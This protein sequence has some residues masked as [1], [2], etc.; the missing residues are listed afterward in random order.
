MVN[1]QDAPSGDGASG[2]GTGSA[3]APARPP[4]FGS[5]DPSPAPDS[6]A[7]GPGATSS[8]GTPGATAPT[9]AGP[10]AVE[11]GGGSSG[12]QLGGG[13]EPGTSTGP[14][15]QAP[16]YTVPGFYGLP[17]TT[18]TGGT[19]RLARPRFRYSAG[20]SIGYDD[21]VFQT[22][23]KVTRQPDQL[24]LIDP[25]TPDILTFVPVTT[26]TYEQAFA[27]PIIYFRPVTTTRL[28]QVIIPGRDPVFETVR[29]PDPPERIG[30]FVSRATLQADMQ[31][32]TRR[33]LFTADL[34]TRLDHYWSRPKPSDKD[35]YSGTLALAYLYRITPRLQFS[36]ATNIAYITQPD[37]TRI[38]T[39]DRLGLGDLVNGLAR[40]NLSYRITPRLS[41]TLSISENA[42]YF[43]EAGREA[44]NSYETT[45]GTEVRYLWKPR[46]TLLA[47]LR[48]SQVTFPEF[49]LRDSS[50]NTVLLGGEVTL[51]SRLTAS[52]RFGAS[53]RT[54]DASDEVSTS[55]SVEAT[56][57][58]RLGATS[59]IQWNSRY[60][61]E[62]PPDQSSEVIAF[63]TSL[64]Y[65]K[66]F[67]PRL[68]ARASFFTV[69]RTTTNPIVNFDQTDITIEASLGLQYRVTRQVT[70]NG[71]YSFTQADTDEE[72][73][74]YVRN[75]LFFGVEYDF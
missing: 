56:L 73:T 75:R 48:H 45:F 21:N 44:N 49:T 69:Y 55:P 9:T 58:Y 60:G 8:F 4:V 5:P 64:T 30:S 1:A 42:V 46:Y 57:N 3:P 39:P 61:F 24:I 22:P 59:L 70:L 50:T 34:S 32:F 66:S 71:D 65:T 14:F 68:N 19:G 43:T 6:P 31:S 51:T 63:R 28:Q 40:M 33:S 10:G 36:L 54:F 23:S 29:A 37:L 15:E 38:N 52:I 67:T 18:Y 11:P 35:D 17:A 72:F 53:F 74:N 20:T 7:P 41:A 2:S 16:S 27:G 13:A 62:E 12:T 47:E 26:T 25:G